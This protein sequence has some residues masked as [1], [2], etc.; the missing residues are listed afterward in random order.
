M[1][2]IGVCADLRYCRIRLAVS[3]PSMSGMF[4]VQQD[5]RELH[6]QDVAQRLLPR[7]GADDVLLQFVQDGAEDDMLFRQV[8]HHQDVDFLLCPLLRRRGSH[9][10]LHWCSH[11]RRT[12]SRSWVFTGLDR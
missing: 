1:K 4:D 11:A 2:T 6:L 5:H 7:P 8:V 9:P 3:R 10:G 12:D